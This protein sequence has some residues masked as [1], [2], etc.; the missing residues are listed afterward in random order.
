MA[1]IFGTVNPPYEKYGTVFEGLVP[2]LNNILRLVVVIAGLFALFNLIIGGL[3]FMAAGGD[4]KQI[5]KSWSRIWNSLV[6]LIFI[7]GSFVLA[8][9]FGYLLF[10]DAMAILNPQIYGPP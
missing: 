7:V 5:E 2:F 6:G 9:I 8:A 4:T 1:T 10:G 3:G